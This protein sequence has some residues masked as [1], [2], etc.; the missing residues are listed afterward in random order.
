MLPSD[1]LPPKVEHLTASGRPQRVSIVNGISYAPPMR[2]IRYFD[3]YVVGDRFV[4][5][6][7]TITE[8]M[9]LQFA[10]MYDT[11]VFH[12]NLDQ[13]AQSNFGGLIG[14]G[15]Q[16][17]NFSFALF[18]RLELV[19]PVALGGPGLDNLRWTRPLRPG[20]T[21]HVVCEV[22]QARASRSKPDRGMLTMRHDTFNQADELILTF[23][24]M[25]LLRRREAA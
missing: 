18:F 16:T 22:T 6:S 5:D 13:A 11:Q 14:S 24:C 1:H 17:L 20:D 21:I 7:V 12:T 15:L 8:G 3:D 9:I 2:P 4:T 25:H 10:R 19:Q 23:D